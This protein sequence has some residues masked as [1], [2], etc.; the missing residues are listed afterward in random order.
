MT[1]NSFFLNGSLARNFDTSYE[2]QCGFLYS[3]DK[4]ELEEKISQF[5]EQARYA[6]RPRPVFSQDAWGIS[7]DK[8]FYAKLEYMDTDKTYYY[9]AGALVYLSANKRYAFFGEIKSV[10]TPDLQVKVVSSA[11]HITVRSVSLLGGFVIQGGLSTNNSQ[12]SSFLYSD[13]YSTVEDLAAYGPEVK[14]SHPA[15]NTD[16]SAEINGL[17]SN[18]TYYYVPRVK[19]NGKDFYG[20]VNSFTTMRSSIPTTEIVDLGLSVKWRGWNLGANKPEEPGDYY[21][22]GETI[23][24]LDGKTDFSRETY[25]WAK[26]DEHLGGEPVPY[27]YPVQEKLGGKWSMPVEANF[28]ELLSNTIHEETEINGTKG[29][30]FFIKTNG[31]G[32]FFPYAGMRAGTGLLQGNGYYWCEGRYY[33]R[34][35]FV[36]RIFHLESLRA[37]PYIN[38]DYE[39]LYRPLGLSIRPVWND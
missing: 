20:E 6:D 26:A 21:A 27:E 24:Y 1:E 31:N 38:I 3:E 15:S 13:S 36:N 28:Q 12:G 2:I 10:T 14:A 29:I 5:V 11:Q 4:S 18:T 35:W 7:E 32:V 23:G 25:K 34:S 33:Y 22:F 37:Y 30:V 16:F 8:S 9:V 19:I 17:A 39:D